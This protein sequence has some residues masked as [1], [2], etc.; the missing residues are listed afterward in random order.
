MMPAFNQGR[1][2]MSFRLISPKRSTTKGWPCG[3]TVIFAETD[4]VTE[5]APTDPIHYAEDG[6]LCCQACGTWLT[7]YTDDQR[8]FDRHPAACLAI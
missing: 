4:R 6:D 8:L 3:N 1:K 5:R 7:C 2:R